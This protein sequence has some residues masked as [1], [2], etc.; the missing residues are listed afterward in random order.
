MKYELTQVHNQAIE[1]QLLSKKQ[2]D[3]NQMKEKEIYREKMLA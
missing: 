2:H 3:S 1:R